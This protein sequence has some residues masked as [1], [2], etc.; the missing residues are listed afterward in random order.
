MIAVQRGFSII[1]LLITLVVLGV[2][3]ALAA[4]AFNEWMQNQQIRAAAEATLNSL[5]SARG[6]AIGRNVNVSF[7][8]TT[9]LTSGCAPAPIG[10]GIYIK[11][12][13]WVVS[14]GDPTNSCDKQ[15][16]DTP[17]GPVILKGLGGEGTPN[18]MLT[19]EPGG[20]TTVTFTPLGGI[21]SNPDGSNAMTALTVSNPSINPTSVRP[22]KVVINPGGTT[23]MCDPS[24]TA[25]DTRACP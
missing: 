4:P 15:I 8:F 25:P 5:Q 6:Q 9:D 1:E 16:T 22:L 20:A 21:T 11:S 19:T 14:S 7:Q 23:R 2:L 17:P 18:A 12:V 10:A 13:S 3:I 24:V